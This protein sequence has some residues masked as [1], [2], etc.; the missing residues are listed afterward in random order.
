MKFFVEVKNYYIYSQITDSSA[1]MKKTG[2]HKAVY[3]Y[4]N[5]DRKIIVKLGYIFDT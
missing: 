2:R 5:M 3:V 4:R 1:R